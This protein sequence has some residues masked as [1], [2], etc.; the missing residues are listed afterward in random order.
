MSEE[1]QIEKKVGW[2]LVACITVL[3]L[4]MFA[5]GLLIGL[6]MGTDQ[7]CR[8]SVQTQSVLDTPTETIPSQSDPSDGEKQQSELIKKT[9]TKPVSPEFKE[10]SPLSEQPDISQPGE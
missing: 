9:E 2:I 6:R 1:I 10:I 5:L 7:G 4:L 8:Q 3:I